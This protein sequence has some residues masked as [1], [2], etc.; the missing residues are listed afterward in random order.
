[1]KTYIWH[2]QAINSEFKNTE[3]KIFACYNI[4]NKNN[5]KKHQSAKTEKYVSKLA[6][7]RN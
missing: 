6:N 4:I 2:I 7:L 1:M 5:V 3:G